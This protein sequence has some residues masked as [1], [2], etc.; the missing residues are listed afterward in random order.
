LAKNRQ[1]YQLTAEILVLAYDPKDAEERAHKQVFVNDVLKDP[2]PADW[3]HF[4]E[5]NKFFSSEE[6]ERNKQRTIAR[7]T[8]EIQQLEK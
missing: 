7:I 3:S 5:P 1:I 6:R 8:Q 2:V 4:D